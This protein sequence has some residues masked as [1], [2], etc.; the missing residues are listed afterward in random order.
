MAKIALVEYALNT[1]QSCRVFGISETCYRY[2]AKRSDE[3]AE[4]ADWLL[5]LTA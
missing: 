2:E 5:L 1:R 3:N 4:T